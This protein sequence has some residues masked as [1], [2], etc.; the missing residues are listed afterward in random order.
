[1]FEV[2]GDIS[3]FPKSC[4]VKT[5]FTLDSLGLEMSIELKIRTTKITGKMLSH[6]IIDTV[7]QLYYFGVIKWSNYF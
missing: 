6:Y 5:S 2:A 1:M 4:L 7:V 3:I